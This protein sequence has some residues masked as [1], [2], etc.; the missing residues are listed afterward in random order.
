[1]KL[2]NLLIL[3]LLL[4]IIGF[5]AFVIGSYL[6]TE[7]QVKVDEQRR[8]DLY[9]HIL[10][11][12]SIQPT[13][14]S[15]D[16]SKQISTGSPLIFGGVHSPPLEQQ[17]AWDKLA[18]VGASLIRTDF[19]LEYSLPRNISLNDYKNNVNNIQNPSTWNL[20]TINTINQKYAYAKKRG[21]KVMGIV[22]Y[23]PGWLTYDGTE[24]GVPKDWEVYED[25]VK[26]IYKI[27]RN[28]L[29]YLEIWNEPTSN[30]FLNIKNSNLTPQEAYRQIFYHAAKAIRDVDNEKN[31][32]KKVLIGGPAGQ[33]PRDTSFLETI[34]DNNDTKKYLN[35]ISYHN[36][37]SDEPSWTNYKNIL[38][39]YDMEKLPIFITEW[40]YDGKIKE[41]NQ[42]KTSTPAIYYT[43]NKFIDF[44]KMGLAGANYYS[45]NP[46]IDKSVN[47]WDGFLGFYR[48]E[49]GKAE[50][51]PQARTWKL[52]SKQMKLGKGDSKI[53]DVKQMAK[54]E[55][56]IESSLTG[57]MNDLLSPEPLNSIGFRN[58]D[59]QYGTAIVNSSSSPQTVNVI[60]ENT[61]IKNY[62]KVQVY[63]ATAGNE[64]KVPVYE[65]LLKVTNGK[66]NF[67]FYIPEESVVGM[68]FTEEKEWYDIPPMIKLF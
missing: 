31:D 8:I 20:K 5:F 49:N 21:M 51:L 17:D 29:D 62:A 63:F 41:D 24:H 22:C 45:Y 2:R 58:I 57:V 16:F 39:K 37:S 35:F 30:Y 23:T 19:V 6:W 65:G 34:L 1:M 7:H 10:D 12:A 28:Y 68:T 64:A 33:N 53:Y 67:P 52:L 48:W 14:L 50:L 40:N 43:A 18:E 47:Q 3:D 13:Q 46:V 32:G 54:S 4:V 36:Y 15:I 25:L 11:G 42:Y 38:K 60:L 9:N 56:Q 61:N 26:K 44:L 59:N 66:I 55:G 27:H